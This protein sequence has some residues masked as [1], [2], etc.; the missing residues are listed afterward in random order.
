MF[1]FN[2]GGQGLLHPLVLE[3]LHHNFQEIER[4]SAYSNKANDW[5]E[6]E[7]DKTRSVLSDL[8][9]VDSR[10]ITLTQNTTEGCNIA[11]WSFPWQKGDHLLLS[12]CEHPGIV[13]IAEVLADRFGISFS[14][15]PL[16]N[17]RDSADERVLDIISANIRPDTK[18]MMVSHICWN[19][20]QV[21]P[22]QKISQICQAKGIWLAVD[23]AQSV[24]VLPL[25]L[26]E[27]GV[28]FYAF[29]GH[30]WLNG[31]LGLG[32]LYVNPL[33]LDE[34]L[35]TFVG[36]RG[37]KQK[38]LKFE[39]AS[40]AY[41][42]LGALRKA[43]ELENNWGNKNDRY[44]SIVNKATDLWHKLKQLANIKLVCQQTP[45]SGLVSF[46]ILDQSAHQISQLLEQKYQIYL[47]SIP[48]PLALRASVS[49][50]T[51]E[52]DHLISI[53]QTL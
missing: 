47:R 45:R 44:Q 51:N 22:L 13:R 49:Y 20:G 38:H 41:P 14:F 40:I 31:P 52:I 30:K 46:Q 8:L 43:I 53:L 42:L 25:N 28:D 23:A 16:F 21:L 12:D 1:Y 24:G 26:T 9:Q 48:Y 6:K 18:M 15:F 27:L 4:L 7:K 33:R 2:Y 17:D 19:T 39:V 35:P 3:T 37:L 10:S 5:I 29:T 34:A 50:K 11:L 36:W 32:G